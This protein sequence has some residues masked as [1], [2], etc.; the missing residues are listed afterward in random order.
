V[1]IGKAGGISTTSSTVVHVDKVIML[2]FVTGLYLSFD[3][4]TRK[5]ARL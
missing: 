3:F 4:L 2:S 1:N 5:Q